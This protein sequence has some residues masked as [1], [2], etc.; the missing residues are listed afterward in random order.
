MG[1]LM[2]QFRKEMKKAN[3]G[4]SIDYIP[5]YRTGIDIFDYINAYVKADGEISLGIP[6]GKPMMDVGNSGSGKS[7]IIIQQACNIADQFEEATIRHF[8]FERSTTKERVMQ[9]ANWD[10]DHY[11]EKYELINHNISAESIF[12]AIKS[13]EKIK[14]DNYDDLKI[15]TGKKDKLT[16]EDIYVLPPTIIIIDSIALMAPEDIENDDELKGSMGASAIA[17]ANTNI[18]KR[19]LSPMENANIIL[20][21]VNHLTQKIEIGP[22][23]SKAQVNYLKQDESIP[24]KLLLPVSYS[25]VRLASF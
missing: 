14:M 1:L 25:N 17:K 18:F 3:Y 6:A 13:I 10:E 8:D 23:H 9:L 21:C 7:S 20:M 24:G 5:S 19:I 15:K 4:T 11:Y 22:V 16:G 2:N 12:T